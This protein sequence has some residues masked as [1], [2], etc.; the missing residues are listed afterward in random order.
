MAAKK[1]NKTAYKGVFYITSTNPTTGANERIY[2]IR[3]YKNGKSIEEKAGRQHQDRMTPAKANRLRVLRIEGRVDSNEERREKVR[4]KR[5]QKNVSRL[6][7]AFYDAKQE[8]KSIKDDRNRWRSYLLKDFGNKLPEEITTLDVDNLRRKLQDRGLAPGTVKQGLVLLKRILNFA[9]KRGLCEPINSGRL[10][11]EM[12]KLNNTKTEDLTGKQLARLLEAIENEPNKS[13]GSL[14]LMALY[15]GMRKGEIYRLQW[16]DIDFERGFILIRDPKGGIDQRI[17][18][19]TPARNVLED[20][21]TRTGNSEWIFPGRFEGHVKDMRE[22]LERI[23]TNAGLPK[24]FRPMHG[25]RH[26]FASTLASSGQV[27]MYTLQ[28]LL[29]HKSPAMVQRYA[30]LRDDAMQRASEVAGDMY[31]AM[32]KKKTTA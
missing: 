20:Q 4:T 15:T 22:P 30:H 31:K 5:A 16:Q 27:D 21:Q 12:P 24:D 3:Y 25:L 9:A 23:R 19:N 1:R 28:K 7:E 11:F 8:N 13:A 26:V 14:M 17:P 6:W 18:I 10:H 32:Q 2:Y 29:T